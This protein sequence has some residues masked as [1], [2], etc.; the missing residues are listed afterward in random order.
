MAM[1]EKTKEL[2]AF[3][4]SPL[5][6][7]VAEEELVRVKMLIDQG[8]DV[9]GFR[10]H[11]LPI[12]TACSG[13]RHRVKVAEYL[14]SVKGFD[15][16]AANGEGE[17]FL[18][19]GV[20][21]GLYVGSLKLLNIKKIIA[22]IGKSSGEEAV[23]YLLN[24]KDAQGRTLLHRACESGRADVAE[25]LISIGAN[26]NAVDDLGRNVLMVALSKKDQ[27]GL[28]GLQKNSAAL[29]D[30]II[31]KTTEVDHVD[32]NGQ[33]ALSY[34]CKIGNAR[35]VDRLFAKGAGCNFVDN[36]GNPPLF[37][38]SKFSMDQHFNGPEII[39][40]FFGYESRPVGR[41]MRNGEDIGRRK[42]R[43]RLNE[44]YGP[45]TV[46]A[47]FDVEGLLAR[48][49]K[50][51]TLE[52]KV[53]KLIEDSQTSAII[54]SFIDNGY[55]FSMPGR[56]GK[57]V[58]MLI[59]D[60]YSRNRQLTDKM[61]KLGASK[62]LLPSNVPKYFTDQSKYENIACPMLGCEWS[63]FVEGI[64][65]A[66]ANKD[67]SLYPKAAINEDGTVSIFTD[68]IEGVVTGDQDFIEGLEE[69]LQGNIIRG[70][71]KEFIVEQM[72]YLAY[73]MGFLTPDGAPMIAFDNSGAVPEV[74]FN[75]NPEQLD[76]I[77]K[78]NSKYSGYRGNVSFLSLKEQVKVKDGKIMLMPFFETQEGGIVMSAGCQFTEI[79]TLQLMRLLP[80]YESEILP[81]HDREGFRFHWVPGEVGQSLGIG[82]WDVAKSI[83][84]LFAKKGVEFIFEA[85]EIPDS[86]KS[87]E[88][89]GDSVVDIDEVSRDFY[90]RYG[91]CSSDMLESGSMKSLEVDVVDF[92]EAAKEVVLEKGPHKSKTLHLGN[93]DAM[94]A[95][96]RSMGV[97][98]LAVAAPGAAGGGAAA[99]APRL[100]IGAAFGSSSSSGLHRS[101]K[102]PG[103]VRPAEHKRLDDGRSRDVLGYI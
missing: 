10:G 84:R 46:D 60:G 18:A 5:G 73:K 52:K 7:G 96:E 89:P 23:N 71:Q 19:T 55:D 90:M 85:E 13:W 82:R 86:F 59:D 101:S 28:V 98:S 14:T 56:E 66:I 2:M 80:N 1:Q 53:T 6:W 20:G 48:G 102:P 16:R 38:L 97:A 54:S 81:S 31:G 41:E 67:A 40:S 79:P 15:Y 27:F 92:L 44:F 100:A 72:N 8:A 50:R 11:D 33:S 58:L 76:A 69:D 9:N 43:L 3:L 83:S 93:I 24:C 75:L 29:I 37:Y 30:E 65:L 42:G 99:A 77:F 39:L 21:C 87:S 36:Q 63:P 95:K 64:S 91:N 74:K 25:Y 47:L 78:Q 26:V 51:F 17:S 4:K 68:A 70:A 94:I 32:S 49:P 22:N 12:M 62:Y 35:I 88:L 61:I 45:S 103:V 34:A 57:N